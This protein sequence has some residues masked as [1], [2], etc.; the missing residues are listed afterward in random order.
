[1]L[2]P[3]GVTNGNYRCSLLGVDL[4]RRWSNPSRV[5]HPTI[6]NTK[7]LIKMLQIERS[8]VLFCD[9]HGHSRKK[10]VFM[11]GCFQS[12]SSSHDALRNNS[13]IRVMPHLLS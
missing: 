9:V 8:V 3:D 5:L 12:L 2:N 11:Y 1:M 4:N 6:F 10:N 13:L 7:Q